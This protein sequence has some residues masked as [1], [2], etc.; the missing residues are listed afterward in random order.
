[1]PEEWN[2]QSNASCF[3]RFSDSSRYFFIRSMASIA[4]RLSN[5][6]DF[7]FA[8]GEGTFTKGTCIGIIA[9]LFQFFYQ[10]IVYPNDMLHRAVILLSLATLQRIILVSFRILQAQ[11][12]VKIHIKALPCKI[13]QF[14]CLNTQDPCYDFTSDTVMGFIP[15]ILCMAIIYTL[16]KTVG[17]SLELGKKLR[18]IRTHFI[19]LLLYVCKLYNL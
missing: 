6:V 17:F 14:R 10:A 7:P 8:I 9:D 15:V 18:N 12:T 3:W 11:C 13:S 5:G 1:M 16:N 2:I 19:P 4:C